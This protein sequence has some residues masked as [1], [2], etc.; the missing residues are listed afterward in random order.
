MLW[1]LRH[2]DAAEAAQG[3][4]DA[5]RPLTEK[6]REQARV[7]G[8]ALA[9]LGVQLDACLS[10]PRLRALDTARLAC[11]Q[12]EGDVEIHVAQELGGGGDFPEA[13]RLAA[14]FGEHVLLVGHNP[15]IS[16]AVYDLTGA[17]VRMKKGALAA[18]EKHELHAFLRPADLRAIARD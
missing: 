13:D 15:E 11:E 6:G 10:S 4:P 14:G 7:A 3:Q 8:A 17:T 9:K 1:L 5:E 18:V 16:E 2:A 12:L